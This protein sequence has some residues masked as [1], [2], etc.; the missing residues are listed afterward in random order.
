MTGASELFLLGSGGTAAL[1]RASHAA[2]GKVLLRSTVVV[3]M[4]MSTML[5]PGCMLAGAVIKPA[6]QVCGLSLSYRDASTSACPS[7][8]PDRL[9]KCPCRHDVA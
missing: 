8:L 1:L 5:M 4:I 2:D 9:G 3:N 7:F 6:A